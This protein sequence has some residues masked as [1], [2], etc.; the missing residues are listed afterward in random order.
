MSDLG[1]LS[2]LN[3]YVGDSENADTLSTVQRES[4]EWRRI[5][6]PDHTIEEQAL[7]VCEEAGELAHAVLKFKQGIRGYDLEKTRKEVSDAIG[8]IVIYACG[9]ADKLGIDD[10]SRA[11]YEAWEHVRDRNIV[12]GSDPG[13]GPSGVGCYPPADS[14]Y[15]KANS[16]FF[17]DR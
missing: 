16:D 9:V 15:D 10:V 4:G 3:S 6:Y 13:L 5:A 7:G 2:D 1:S 8:D 12:A 11:V 14:E 17:G